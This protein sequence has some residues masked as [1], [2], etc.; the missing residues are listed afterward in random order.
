MPQ[1]PKYLGYKYDLPHSDL[2]LILKLKLASLG[3]WLRAGQF[4]CQEEI[5]TT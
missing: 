1:P 3:D 4:S 5:E 2:E